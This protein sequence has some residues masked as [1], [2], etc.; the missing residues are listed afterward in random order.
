MNVR[1]RLRG[2]GK[3]LVEAPESRATTLEGNWY[4]HP[5]VVQHLPLAISDRLYSCPGK[6]ICNWVDLE[7]AHGFM[8][9]VAWVYRETLPG[10]AHINGWF[11]FYG[12]EARYYCETS[13]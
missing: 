11:G 5:D 12:D 8:N 1:V 10:Y 7:T 2:S 3:L 4:F 6:G 9:N 13:G